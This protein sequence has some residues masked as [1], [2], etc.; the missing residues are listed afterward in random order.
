MSIANN[1]EA[2]ASA[3]AYGSTEVLRIAI[4]TRTTYNNDNNSLNSH[5]N[6]N[7]KFIGFIEATATTTLAD[8]RQII[9]N[10]VE[11]TP[12]NF[13]F[14]LNNNIPVG[15]RQEQNQI[16]L[17][18]IPCL[19]LRPCV[20]NPLSKKVNVY[21]QVPIDEQNIL[22]QNNG[23]NINEET[24]P[25]KILKFS[26]W[27]TPTY[28]FNKLRNDAS[29]FFN[30]Q[31]ENTL[32][33]DS[34]NCDDSNA[35]IWPEEALV[36]T[37]INQI[38][39]MSFYNNQQRT[40]M[41]QIYL[42]VRKSSLQL[43][44]WRKKRQ[45]EI[46]KIN[47]EHQ[48]KEIQQITNTLHQNK[49]KSPKSRNKYKNMNGNG[50][51][52][53]FNRYNTSSTSGDTSSLTN[54]NI[55]NQNIDLNVNKYNNE[56]ERE[57][58]LIFTY[59]CV[60]A[61]PHHVDRLSSRQ[62]VRLLKDCHI[63][64]QTLSSP[65]KQHQNNRNNYNEINH[66]GRKITSAMLH[67]I[68]CSHASRHQHRNQNDKGTQKRGLA[69]NMLATSSSFGGTLITTQPPSPSNLEYYSTNF[70]NNSSN[71]TIN[72]FAGNNN[73]NNNKSPTNKRNN[74]ER[75]K[76]NLDEFLD[77]LLEVAAMVYGT[78]SSN[79]NIENFSFYNNTNFNN[80]NYNSFNKLPKLQNLT[81]A[82]AEYAFAE[83]L[84]SNILPYACRWSQ[85][86]W[87]NID[88]LIY[89]CTPIVEPSKDGNQNNNI[90]NGGGNE[91]QS[92]TNYIF[93]VMLRF[94]KPLFEIFRYYVCT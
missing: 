78:S 26:T 21:F 72:N 38:N 7:L 20:P 15:I 56:F 4:E 28:T 59:Y 75:N 50:N 8:A 73:I 36:E 42:C 27:I 80:N 76:M 10:E 66:N 37:V 45:K 57:L 74:R 24:T 61:N 9:T 43:Y 87:K 14:L 46:N 5:N 93:N 29:H 69:S 34:M 54:Q 41:P 71:S 79:Q 1:Q 60:Q 62:F 81:A 53:N 89:N 44:F 83:L 13:H 92:S 70:N 67:V 39:R 55:Q 32:L 31:P 17:N 94:R 16:A 88:N 84:L 19:I 33:Q 49:N 90:E 65:N 25:P 82:E 11:N 35:S 12:L 63:V 40:Q 68:Y 18:F 91:V 22:Q 52:N 2:V 6:Q 47:I 77:A 30:L 51:F 86:E 23:G 64:K 58:W 48:Q 85:L 3:L